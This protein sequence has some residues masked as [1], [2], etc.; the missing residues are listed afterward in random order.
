MDE[1]TV[2]L[3][4]GLAGIS[5]TLAASVLTQWGGR[6]A[7]RERRSLEDSTRW[8]PER[9]RL[10]RDVIAAAGSIERDLY[11][12]AAFLRNLAENT[13]RPLWL[14]G[15]NNIWQVPDE[16]VPGVLSAEDRDELRRM[17]REVMERTDLLEGAIAEIA[18]IGT[19][20]EALAADELFDAIL[21]ASAPVESFGPSNTA[22]AALR[23]LRSARFAYMAAARASLRVDS[24]PTRE[25]GL[26]LRGTIGPRR[27]IEPR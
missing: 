16:G 11:G 8:L 19:E 10:N 7:E 1:T 4:V 27:D 22:Y 3:L 26:R 2:N 18:V 23:R 25:T 13:P 14:G 5:G 20:A 17:V 12:A 6:R 9:L 15:F 24:P 21:T